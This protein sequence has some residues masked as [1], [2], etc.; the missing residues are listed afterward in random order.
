MRLRSTAPVRS[1]FQMRGK[2]AASALAERCW[3]LAQSDF[4][5]LPF[6]VPISRIADRIVEIRIAS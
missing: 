6:D 5:Y 2:S 1:S 4:D 3:A